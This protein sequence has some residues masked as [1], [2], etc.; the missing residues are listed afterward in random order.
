VAREDGK[1]ES[2]QKE[3]CGSG[4]MNGGGASFHLRFE[5]R[6]NYTVSNLSKTVSV[7]F[8]RMIYPQPEAVS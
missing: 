7:L 3:G 1:E 4:R 6:A 5:R 2:P 8:A